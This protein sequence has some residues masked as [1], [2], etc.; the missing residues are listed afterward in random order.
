MP[1][2]PIGIEQFVATD[3]L[4]RFWRGGREMIDGIGIM[5]APNGIWVRPHRK[6]FSV[7]INFDK[8]LVLE[9]ALAK[10]Q[11]SEDKKAARLAIDGDTP[12][13]RGIVARRDS[14]NG[15]RPRGKTIDPAAIGEAHLERGGNREHPPAVFCFD[16]DAEA[17]RASDVVRIARDRK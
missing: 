14:V 6:A 10:H 2:L 7:R 4:N 3:R 9:F 12:L 1:E 16:Q 15:D 5:L 13:H 8:A 11:M 17:A